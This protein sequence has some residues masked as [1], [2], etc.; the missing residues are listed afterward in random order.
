MNDASFSDADPAP[1]A[2]IAQ[3][4]DDLTVISTLV[5]DSVLPVTEIS[6]DMRHRQL[7]LLLNRFRWED[8]DQARRDERPYERVRSVLLISDVQRVQSDG[9][10]RADT[11]LILELLAVRWEAGADG[12][13]RLMLEFAGDGT[14]A[15]EAEC[16]N[17]ELRD[18]TRPY[19][20]P[21]RRAPEHPED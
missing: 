15:I 2:L 5:Q 16:L 10:D 19:I 14:L 6:Y 13:G 3:D 4:A 9:I 11:D 8:A 18:V 7:A 17:L 12:T 1:L 20:A 21:S